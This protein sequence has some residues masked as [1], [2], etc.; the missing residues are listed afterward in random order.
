[1]K[2]KIV[3]VLEKDINWEIKLFDFKV[4]IGMRTG[5]DAMKFCAFIR[6]N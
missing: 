1:M 3:D 4:V 6:K 2:G 5:V